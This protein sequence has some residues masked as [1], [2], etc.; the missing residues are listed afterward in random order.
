MTPIALA[1]VDGVKVVVPSA[2][3]LMT[4][5]VLCEQHDWFEDEVRFLRHLLKP[6]Q[7]VIDIGANYGVYTLPMARTVG[8]TGH[9]WCFEPASTTAGYLAQSIATNG[10]AHVSLEKSALSSAS[11]TAQL[12]LNDNAELNELVRGGNAAGLTETVP[13]ITLDECLERHDWRDITFLKIDAEGEEAKILLGGRRFFAELSPLI[14]YEVK[15]G[16]DVHLDLVEAFAALGYRSYRLV[17]GLNLLVPFSTQATPDGYLL[18]LFCCKADRAELLAA[19]GYLV[20][21]LPEPVPASPDRYHWRQT[22]AKLPYGRQL[23]GQWEE[24]VKVGQSA[25]VE[26]ALALFL[27]SQDASLPAAERF[28]CLHASLQKLNGAPPSYLRLGSLARVARAYGARTIA[29]NALAQL[30]SAIRL[31]GQVDLS[32][33]F[34]V[35]AA[36][37]EQT[38]PG[39]KIGNWILAAALEEAE[40]LTFFSSYY[41]GISAKPRLELI[42]NLGFASAEMQRRLSLVK[43]RF[44]LP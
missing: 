38:V 36:R 5:Y 37:F 34:L 13:L 12:N 23:A 6:G 30:C 9:V 14:E 1:L 44:P 19:Q 35:P 3:N 10:F 2:L 43:Q 20:E 8:P 18:N 40:S 16:H 15:A 7:K 41:S 39:E 27:Q 11:G 4:P 29:V 24:T 33:P 17:P 28:A 22:L 42:C 26:S 25:E 32:E 21:A 31:R